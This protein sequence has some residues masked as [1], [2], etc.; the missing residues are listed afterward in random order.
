MTD[1][2]TPTA[3]NVHDGVSETRKLIGMLTLPVERLRTFTNTS[4][5]VRLY[6]DHGL[7][8]K[9]VGKR[10]DTLDRPLAERLA[11]PQL[12]AS[13]D[14]PNLARVLAATEVR[15][16]TEPREMYP[17]IEIITPYYSRGSVH[18]VLV[19]ERTPWSLTDALA[20]GSATARGLGE[21]HRAGFV[22]RDV[23]STNIFLTGDRHFAVV[24]DLG[25][26]A[27][28]AD[29]TAPGIETA[30][31][32]TA[33]EQ[34]A[35]GL[36]SPQT[37]LFGLGMVMVEA[38]RGGFDYEGYEIEKAIK[39]LHRGLPALPVRDLTLPAT[40]PPRLRR[41]LRKLTA[42]DPARRPPSAAEVH[43][44]LSSI[45]FIEWAELPCTPHVRRWEG[46]C[47]R[48]PLHYAVEARWRPRL[49]VWDVLGYRC[50]TAWRVCTAPARVVDLEGQPV[51]DVFDTVL[52]EAQ[53]DAK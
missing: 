27:P 17:L 14:H 31:P 32:W 34:V 3:S 52:R 15:G 26:A 5:A 18:E 45:Y 39:R 7:G 50:R 23:K 40:V 42:A 46:A 44:L 16:G 36:A 51:F 10:V 11:E 24:G 2:S 33:P 22:H 49:G 9:V 38:L 47:T 21:M 28:L 1:R 37:D 13:F 20:L 25:E 19:A 6:Q 30:H 41:L 35:Q 12:Q 29:R 8:M 53:R 4:G 43:D 48:S